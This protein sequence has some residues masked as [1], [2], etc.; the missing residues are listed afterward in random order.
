M[1]KIDSHCHAGLN[2]YEPIELLLYQM[3]K[4]DV[5][6]AVL[7]QHRGCFDNLYLLECARKFPGRLSV[8]GLLDT[9][10]LD[11][12]N[13]L[14]KWKTLG[15][16]GIRLQPKER[17]PGSD[18]L[19]IWK[20][21]AELGLV[22][23]CLGTFEEY[24]SIEFLNLVESVPNL[25]IVIEHLA[26]ATPNN[27]NWYELFESGMKIAEYP[28]VYIKVP[29]LGEI[30]ERPPLLKPCFTPD[31]GTR[32]IEIAYEMFGSRR[33]MWGSDYPP[34]SAREGYS[35]ALKGVMDNPVFRTL[36]DREWVMGKTALTVFEFDY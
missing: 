12:L 31:F 16:N 34:V 27:K 18:P 3:N 20:N 33:M 6:K 9:Q 1:L 5:D 4:N 10:D 23:S 32:Y 25:T 13:T 19:A 24:G 11:A 2:W 22:V 7:V 21:S 17:S 30:T 15:I 26:G 35:N 8:V 28:N 36:E 14:E 29:G